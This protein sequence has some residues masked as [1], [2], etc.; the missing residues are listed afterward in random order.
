MSKKKELE[1]Q[2][3]KQQLFLKDKTV[4]ERVV[5]AFFDSFE[6]ETVHYLSVTGAAKKGFKRLKMEV[7]DMFERY[8]SSFLQDHYNDEDGQDSIKLKSYLTELFDLISQFRQKA[9]IFRDEIMYNW[10]FEEMTDE[11]QE[12]LSRSLAEIWRKYYYSKQGN[13]GVPGHEEA[14]NVKL[15]HAYVES[16]VNELQYV[17]ERILD[18]NKE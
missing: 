9:A 7:T 18:I 16:M 6:N 8:W 5:S 13:H 17:A 3:E 4:N 12:A 1:H 14:Q 2:L 10:P 11:S 15:Y